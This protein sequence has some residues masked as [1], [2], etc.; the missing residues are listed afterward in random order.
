V[1]HSE[2]LKRLSHSSDT[3]VGS[4]VEIQEGGRDVDLVEYEVAE[5]ANPINQELSQLSK[6]GALLSNKESLLV[7]TESGGQ[8]QRMSVEFRDKKSGAV[9]QRANFKPKKKSVKPGAGS[10]PKHVKTKSLIVA[11]DGVE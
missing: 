11:G 7:K 3:L 10:S 6:G 4:K 8:M 2:K 1:P 5:A 9:V